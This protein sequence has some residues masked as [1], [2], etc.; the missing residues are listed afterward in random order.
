[1]GTKDPRADAERY[2]ERHNVRGLFKH[3]STKVRHSRGAA[4]REASRHRI[5][6]RCARFCPFSR[7]V[8]HVSPRA[9][10][11]SCRFCSQSPRTPKLSSSR[12]LN[13]TPNTK[14]Q[15]L[16]TKLSTGTH[17]L[18]PK[19]FLVQELKKIRECQQEQK[20]VPSMFEENDLIAMFGMFDVTGCV[21]MACVVVSV[22]V[23]L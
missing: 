21:H 8:V 16:N 13:Q 20:P 9:S 7:P 10:A 2:L 1:M 15:P 3:L 5:A 12:Y 19:P 22:C 23:C 14:L 6:P 17:A 18:N 4:A 11:T